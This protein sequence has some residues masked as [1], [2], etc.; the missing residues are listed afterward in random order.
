MAA[1][2]IDVD[3]FNSG[4]LEEWVRLHSDQF[5][6]QTETFYE[7][8]TGKPHDP[9]ASKIQWG[10]TGSYGG[11]DNGYYQDEEGQHECKVCPS[12]R[13]YSSF[14]NPWKTTPIIENTFLLGLR[15]KYINFNIEAGGC[16]SGKYIATSNNGEFK[17][18]SDTTNMWIRDTN[19]MKTG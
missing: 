6:S 14:D 16:V 18:D 5:Y 3:A 4:V 1:A 15:R 13:F 8:G 19:L 12:G 9:R 11:C 7:S 10:T 17:L 2:P